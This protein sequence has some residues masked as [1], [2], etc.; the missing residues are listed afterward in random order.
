MAERRGEGER[1]IE[2]RG[3]GEGE[4]ENVMKLICRYEIVKTHVD[5]HVALTALQCNSCNTR[6]EPVGRR[7][8][9][10]HYY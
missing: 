8:I 9:N 2:I 6:F 7:Y 4:R 3:E 1:G 10:V 5:V